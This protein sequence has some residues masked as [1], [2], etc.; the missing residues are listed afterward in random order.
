MSSIFMLLLVKI[1]L[2]LDTLYTGGCL[3]LSQVNIFN[4]NTFVLDV[5]SVIFCIAYLK[6]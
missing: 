5:K 2:F 3:Y 4:K 6:I 1:K